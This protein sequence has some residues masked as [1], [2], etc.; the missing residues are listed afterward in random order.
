M[1]TYKSQTL[2][3]PASVEVGQ[4]SPLGDRATSVYMNTAVTRGTGEVLV[5]ATGM[6]TETGRI[7]DMLHT[8]KP[9]PTPLQRQIDTLSRTLAIIA[10]CV[11]VVVFVLGLIRGQQF[12]A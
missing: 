9:G 12:H 5:T 8:A 1:L 6:Q 10:G 11:I 4:D 2:A 7:A 3:N